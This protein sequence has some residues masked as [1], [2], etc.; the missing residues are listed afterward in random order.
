MSNNT[1]KFN[2]GGL[3]PS[4]TVTSSV[5]P[6][7]VNL[8]G[9]GG[10]VIKNY[11]VDNNNQV[12][13]TQVVDCCNAGQV[14][15]TVKFTGDSRNA[16]G[17]SAT[18]VLNV[19]NAAGNATQNNAGTVNKIIAGP[20]I[21]LNNNGEGQVTISLEPIRPIQLNTENFTRVI[22][23]ASDL[24]KGNPSDQSAF[25]AFGYATSTS[26]VFTSTDTNSFIVRSRDGDNWVDLNNNFGIHSNSAGVAI[27]SADLPGSGL[28]YFASETNSN[29]TKQS[30]KWGVEGRTDSAGCGWCSDGLDQTGPE[31]K[32]NNASRA[33]RQ[34]GF[35]QVFYSTGSILTDALYLDF[36][37]TNAAST[38]TD[39]YLYQNS[40]SSF[41][42]TATAST[43]VTVET[44]FCKETNFTKAATDI[45]PGTTSNYKICVVGY[46][47]TATTRGV[48][49]KSTRNS[50]IINTWTTAITTSSAIRGIA[51]GNGLWV[52]VGDNDRC[53]ISTDAVNWQVKSTGWPGANWY[54]VEY[55]NGYFMAVGQGGHI[56][57]TD[58]YTRTWQR[59]QS[60]TT[61]TLRSIAFSPKLCAFATVGDKR[62]L[63]TVQLCNPPANSSLPTV[64][65]NIGLSFGAGCITSW[66]TDTNIHGGGG[67]GGGGGG[68]GGTGGGTWKFKFTSTTDNS[69]QQQS[70]YFNTATTATSEPSLLIQSPWS[71]IVGSGYYID[72]DLHYPTTPTS[73]AEMTFEVETINGQVFSQTQGYT[74]A[75]PAHDLQWQFSL[76]NGYTY[77][78]AYSYGGTVGT[79]GNLAEVG[80]LTYGGTTTQTPPES[81]GHTQWSPGALVSANSDPTGPQNIF[82]QGSPY[83]ITL[84]L[85][86]VVNGAVKNAGNVVA[87]LETHQIQITWI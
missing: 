14:P 51:Y 56:T 66:N 28:V 80:V 76:P 24:K 72:Q 41:L 33:G 84:K 83:L 23:S 2:P 20:G 8:I 63:S 12:R 65:S 32:S 11:N 82:T 87:T 49:Y 9:P 74:L 38:S 77:Y 5:L 73:G 13:F 40:P 53:Y 81:P 16:G 10:K 27:Q 57:Y 70:N 19:P 71:V 3:A 31:I 52:A 86:E 79:G 39:I 4:S 6:G 69:G 48:L 7:S 25:I 22:W 50:N 21:Y 45:S 29:L 55:G 47:N 34:N 30:I 68:G 1:D 85:N 60:G 54:D 15:F 43:A 78:S 61:S 62:A 35:T 36:G 17:A 44:S 58:D 26:S 64:T 37:Y 46:E 18:A 67:T 59:S 75:D 42:T